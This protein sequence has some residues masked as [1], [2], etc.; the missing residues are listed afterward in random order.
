MTILVTGATGF[1]GSWVVRALR[2]RELSFVM[3]DLTR[4]FTRLG[5]LVDD[6]ERLPFVEADITSPSAIENMLFRYDVD[7][8]IHLAALQI[9]QCRADPVAGAAVNVT[10]FLRVFEAVK[11]KGDVKNVVYASSAAVFGPPSIY[12][13][14]PVGEDVVL[15]PTT[16]YG[17][18]K[19]CNELT[20]NAYWFE[21]GISS[22]GLR[23]HTVY[24]FGRDVGVTADV[25]RAIRA[26]ILGSP[27][28]IRFGGIVALQYVADVAE[29]FVRCS[30][31]D[32]RGAR[33]YNLRGEVVEVAE[34]VKMIHRLIPSSE[35][36]ITFEDAPLPIA[37]DLDDTAFRR[38][39]GGPP[40]T[41]VEEG[42][43]ETIQIYE[44][45][46][47]RGQLSIER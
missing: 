19:V 20:A 15:K 42:L 32:L 6:V 13:G 4:D 36:L 47:A 45:L 26:A 39:V 22:V 7:R 23:P 38:E 41:P 16:H 14:G 3:T 8:I 43:R 5:L 2:Q 46:R 30:L 18:F 34:V 31:S 33:V 29:A 17:A 28:K 1:I 10:G 27:F 44:K 25:T 35:K 24:G 37:A 40:P 12:G 11:K 9:P 21:L